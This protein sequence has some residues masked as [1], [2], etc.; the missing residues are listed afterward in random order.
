[1][2]YEETEE[3]IFKLNQD[4]K[5]YLV[6][7][8]IFGDCVRVSCQE[9]LGKDGNFYETDF[10]LEDLSSINRYFILMSSINEAQNELI[11]AIE[12]QQVGI[13]H[14]PNLIKIIFYITIGTDN[15]NFK[16]PLTKR[17][18]IF[19]RIK[20][21]EE[22][23]PFTGMIQLKNKGNY[24][25]DEERI[26]ELEKKNAQLIGSQR[27][28]ISDVKNLMDVTQ[29]LINESNLLYEENAKLNARL[30]KIQK[31]NFERN[32]EVEVLKDEEQALN[33]EN[34]KLKNYNADLERLLQQKRENLARE[35]ME[36]K[37]RPTYINEID[38]GNG[39]KAISSRYDDA[40][41]K[42]FIPRVTAKPMVEAY[43]EGLASKNKPP[44]YYTDQRLPKNLLNNSSNI[45]KLNNTDINYNNNNNPRKNSFRTNEL[46]TNNASYNKIYDNNLN[47]NDN[48]ESDKDPQD[49]YTKRNKKPK[50]LP[51]Q[52]RISEKTNDYEEEENNRNI[53][54]GNVFNN[55]EQIRNN[56]SY[57]N[58]TES[59]VSQVKESDVRDN[60]SYPSN[61][62]LKQNKEEKTS[63]Y[64]DEEEQLNYLNSDIILSSTEEEMLLNKINKH[65]KQTQMKLIYK[66]T[67]DSDRAEIFHQK[68]DSAQRTLV[69]IE[70]INERR[71]GGYTT[72]SWEGNGIDKDDSEAFVFSLDKLQ[73]Y[74]I[75]SGQPAIG[76]YP[77]YGPVFLGCQIKVN[78]NFFVK[79]G[80]TYRKNT[81]YAINSDFELNDG[82]KFF[83]IKEIEVFEVQ[84]I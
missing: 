52:E 25:Q 67:V 65:G 16:L 33:D 51:V 60:D 44:F 37:Q 64:E 27:D 34:I 73:I 48:N 79:G 46:I 35:Y 22:Q 14:N 70:T 39:P 32:L 40:Q 7:I 21:P 75:I 38:Y 63:E 17:D 6:S 31:E 29:K 4:G 47:G 42:T 50:K 84:L 49:N 43:D 1:M 2:E 76:C 77:K 9:N 36:S 41:I 12:K 81:N 15:I 53:R 20:T 72:Q 8:S 62:H 26:V 18:A 55:N 28:L 13:E 69:L 56:E 66:A 10:S 19:K 68:C 80:T 82:V 54:N 11:K 30:Q 45:D 59:Q 78:D 83:G 58:E 5:E 57:F 24:P 71:F 3:K 74:N 23:V 61:Y